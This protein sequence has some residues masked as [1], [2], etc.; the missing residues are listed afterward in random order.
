M[1]SVWTS[2]RA[3]RWGYCGR[4]RWVVGV[5][6]GRRAWRWTLLLLAVDCMQGRNIWSVAVNYNQTLV[7]SGCQSNTCQS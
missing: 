1:E 6:D 5:A 7:V 3:T 4:G 2:L